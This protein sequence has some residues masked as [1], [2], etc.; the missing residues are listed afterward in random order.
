MEKARKHTTSRTCADD[1]NFGD[2]I[3][4]A[5]RNLVVVI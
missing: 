3:V 4:D 1:G 5:L 2:H